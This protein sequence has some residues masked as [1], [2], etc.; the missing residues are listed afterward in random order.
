MEEKKQR[1]HKCYEKKVR[2]LILTI[3]FTRTS[4]YMC[5]SIT[6]CQLKCG[7]V[8]KEKKP[9]VIVASSDVAEETL[10]RV[11]NVSLWDRELVAL[12]FAS[13]GLFLT[14]AVTPVVAQ[15]C[16]WLVIYILMPPKCW[17]EYVMVVIVI[18]LWPCPAV[19]HSLLKSFAQAVNEWKRHLK[20]VGCVVEC[21]PFMVSTW[22]RCLITC[23]LMVKVAEMT[24]TGIP[25]L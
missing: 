16:L 7:P 4:P 21:L 2:C 12:R 1:E 3:L 25:S 9:P 24:C 15:R 17:Q 6:T 19:L 8:C 18:L 5:M 20:H 14:E 22:L 23:V 13:H 10:I 11:V